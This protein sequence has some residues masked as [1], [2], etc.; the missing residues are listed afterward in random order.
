MIM[1]VR[2]MSGTS[3]IHSFI[4][5]YHKDESFGRAY[6]SYDDTG[7]KRVRKP[8][9]P[10]KGVRGSRTTAALSA[11]CKDRNAALLLLLL[12]RSKAG[13]Y[14]NPIPSFRFWSGCKNKHHSCT[15]ETGFLC[16]DGARVICFFTRVIR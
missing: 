1:I 5:S 9:A 3:H 12:L 4:T 14:V 13:S 8:L 15:I 6:S 11:P 2:I 7:S 16:G 10:Q